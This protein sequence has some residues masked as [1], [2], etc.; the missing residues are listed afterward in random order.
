MASAYPEEEIDP[1]GLGRENKQ[2]DPDDF[3]KTHYLVD[4]SQQTKS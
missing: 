4:S 1:F 2:E 3:E